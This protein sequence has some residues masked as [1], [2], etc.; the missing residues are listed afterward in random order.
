MRYIEIGSKS[1]GAEIQSQ[2][3]HKVR[4]ELVQEL[5]EEAGRRRFRTTDP[6][7]QQKA[8]KP[9]FTGMGREKSTLR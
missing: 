8:R 1:K 9:K 2:S 3:E 7:G 6:T 4:L 5:D